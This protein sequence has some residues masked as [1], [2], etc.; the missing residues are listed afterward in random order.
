MM[1]SHSTPRISATARVARAQTSAFD[2]FVRI[3]VLA[4]SALIFLVASAMRAAAATQDS[5]AHSRLVSD[6]VPSGADLSAAPSP[7]LTP[8]EVVAAVLSALSRNDTPVK[9]HGISVTFGFA[10]PANRA[11]VGPI[12]SFADLVR[13]DTYRP[14]LY[15]RHAARGLAHVTGDRATERVVITTSRGEK[16]AYVFTLSLQN[17]GQ[18]KGCWMTDGV[19]REPPS[20]LQGM[21]FAD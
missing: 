4:A 16:V 13:D 21:R 9:D 8:D 17:D 15:H 7:T 3:A 5:A 20:P 14:L 10:S 2:V 19:T 1:R 6:S 11:F 18:Y 12:E